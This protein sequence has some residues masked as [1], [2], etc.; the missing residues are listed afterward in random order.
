MSGFAYLPRQDGKT[1]GMTSRYRVELST[2]GHNWSIVSE[3][4]FG[5][6]R[7]NPVEQFISFPAQKARCFSTAAQK[8]AA[9]F[10]AAAC[11]AA[12]SLLSSSLL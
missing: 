9:V 10:R 3:G 1:V 11:T 4:E 2:D 12:Q 7:A 6:L 8:W 5:N